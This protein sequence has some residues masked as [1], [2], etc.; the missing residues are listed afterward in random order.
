MLMQNM[1]IIGY[2]NMEIYFKHSNAIMIKEGNKLIHMIALPPCDETRIDLLQ[3]TSNLYNYTGFA[4]ITINGNR[5]LYFRNKLIAQYER[6]TYK[7]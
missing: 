1:E 6:K 4:V 7:I 5:F 3:K 2:I